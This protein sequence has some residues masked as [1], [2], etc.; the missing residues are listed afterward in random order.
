[1]SYFPTALSNSTGRE[2][3]FLCHN[4]TYTMNT[5]NVVSFLYLKNKKMAEVRAIQKG[6]S[7]SETSSAKFEPSEF[8]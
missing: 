6:I 2:M 1:M 3:L 7:K 5:S 4:L 8:R